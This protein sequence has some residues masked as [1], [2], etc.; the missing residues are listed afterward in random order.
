MKRILMGMATAAT[1]ASLALAQDSWSTHRGSNQ[2]TGTTDNARNSTAH[3]LLSWTLPDA[4]SVRQPT[5]VDNDNAA[6]TS[7]T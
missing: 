6:L 7:S 4:G 2:R 5:I 1:I 3:F